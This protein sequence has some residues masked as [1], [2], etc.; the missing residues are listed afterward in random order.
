MSHSV[1]AAY[2]TLRVKDATGSDVTQ[3]FY[4]GAVLPDGANEDD[5]ARLVRK[6]MVEDDSKAAK[7]ADNKPAGALASRTKN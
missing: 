3:G 4:E 2:V 7:P 6:G 1:K 5:L